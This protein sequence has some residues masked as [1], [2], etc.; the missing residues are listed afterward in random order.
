MDIQ[1]KP[2]KK[3]MREL[4]TKKPFTRLVADSSYSNHGERFH[5]VM[6]E[7]V[8]MHYLRR[9]I[10]TQGDFLMELDPASHLINDREYYPDVW[11]QNEQDGKWYLEE[12]PRFAFA[13]QNLILTK[14][15]FH[16]TG[17]NIQFEISSKTDDDRERIVCNEFRQGWEDCNMEVAWYKLARSVKATGDGAFIGFLDKGKFGWKVVSYLDGDTLYPHYDLKTGKLN[18]FARTYNNYAEDGSVIKQYCEVWDEKYY[19]RFSCGEKTDTLKEKV[20]QKIADIFDLSGYQLEEKTPHGFDFIPVAYKRDDDG[21]CWSKSQEAIDK[22]EMVFSRMAQ[23]NQLFGLPIMVVKGEGSTELSSKDMTH[24]SK[25]FFLPEDGN[26]EFLKTPDASN[27]FKGELMMLEDLIYTL[28]FVVKPPE[29]KSGDLPAAAI[30]LLYSPAMENATR[31]CNEYDEVVDDMVNIFSFGFGVQSEK[32]LEFQNSSITHYIIPHQ[33]QNESEQTN[34]LVSLVNSKVLSR[35]TA[36][37]KSYYSTPQ[38]YSRIKK[39]EHDNQMTEL[40]LEEQ[41]LELQKDVT[42]ETAEAEA[43]IQAEQQTEM[44]KTGQQTETDK[45][46]K[47]KKSSAGGKSSTGRGTGRKRGRPNLSGRVYDENGN[48]KGRN[49][50]HDDIDHM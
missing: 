43:E 16:L 47:S 39:E 44:I 24:A 13:Y 32:R 1:E 50:W 42:I 33:F 45:T 2:S 35:Q 7:S 6:E 48:W 31:D 25:I 9:K 46:P 17:A 15:L 11:R 37:E 3:F 49:G 34:N 26:M 23:S 28:S 36:S 30:R 8:P 29:L 27:A 41:K 10:V 12:V 21:A 18:V 19:Y 40:M 5:D 20:M 38:E 14:H 4:L 22:Y